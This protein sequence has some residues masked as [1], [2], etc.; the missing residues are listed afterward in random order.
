MNAIDFIQKFGWDKTKEIVS[1][2]DNL[3]MT[4]CCFDI[5]VAT[6]GEF[7]YMD[8]C[9]SWLRPYVDSYELVQSYGGLDCSTKE[10]IK[11]HCSDEPISKLKQA[12]SL[13]EEVENCNEN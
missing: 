1:S 6:G 2:Y 7:E 10:C 12:I 11:L 9:V 5:S 4:N 8:Q 3:G 13:V